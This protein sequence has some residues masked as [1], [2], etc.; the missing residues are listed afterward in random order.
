MKIIVVGAGSFGTAVA[1]SLKKENAI[2]LFT[3]D[4][5][6]VARI[7]ATRR[8]ETYFPNKVLSKKIKAT[9]NA[10]HFI[11]VDVVLICIPS[12]AVINFFNSV[13]VSP[14]ALILN[15]AKG[16]G[17]GTELI[18][19]ALSSFLPN[20]IY[21]FKGPS[22]AD[23]FIYELPTAF[24][25]AGRSSEKFQFISSLFRKD[26][27]VLDFSNDMR[28]VETLSIIKNIYAIIVGIVDASFNSANVRFMIFTKA[29]NEIKKIIELLSIPIETLFKYGGIGDFGLTA[30]ND[31]SRNRTL[32]LLIG[33][34]FFGDDIGNNV[35]LE[36]VRAVEK[37]LGVLPKES[38]HDL[39]LLLKL[40]YLIKKKV[41]VSTFVREVIYN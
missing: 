37:V 22:F 19:Q 34:G 14:D 20:P 13:S 6:N 39:P 26:L 8:N 5:L 28:G 24:T 10:D 30:L 9:N 38:H 18:P 15:G 7:N 4:G 40:S 25:I 2:F 35:V 32:G 36:G 17:K 27:V 21:S 11:D 41:S 23:E 1:N 31:L 12:H 3:R 29:L 33:K 16:F